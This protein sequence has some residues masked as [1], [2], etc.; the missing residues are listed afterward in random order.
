MAA[1]TERAASTPRKQAT[2]KTADPQ[3]KKPAAQAG[4]AAPKKPA[5]KPAAKRASKPAV[6]KKQVGRPSDYTEELGSILC[7]QIAMGMSLRTVCK[8][9]DAPS[10]VTFFTWLR[11][12]PEFLT[13][14]EAAKAESAAALA[15]ELL[16]IADDGTND[17]M[18]IHDKDGACVGYKVNGEHVQRSRLRLD[19]RKWLLSKLAPKKYGDKVDVNHG[20]QEGNPLTVLHRQIRGKT[21]KPV[22][23]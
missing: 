11:K 19:T 3:A 22:T 21:L 5:K 1:T 13:Q 16:D 8:G 7:A 18:E 2:R 17:W 4:K 6:P 20:S 9:E 10:A 15:E 14:Y 23:E 12:H